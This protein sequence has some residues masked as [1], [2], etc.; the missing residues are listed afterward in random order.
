M[1]FT[2]RMFSI[3]NTDHAMYET[4]LPE[5]FKL[6]C[7]KVLKPFSHKVRGKCLL[8]GSPMT[9]EMHFIDPQP[10]TLNPHH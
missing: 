4:S 7:Q 9:E 10:S 2:A 1:Q 6:H 5:S 8:L 3:T